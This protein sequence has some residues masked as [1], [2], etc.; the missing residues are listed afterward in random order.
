MARKPSL[1]GAR[2]R[3]AD[4]TLLDPFKGTKDRPALKSD[5]IRQQQKP[6]QN[7]SAQAT[8]GFAAGVSRIGGPFGTFRPPAHRI[9]RSRTFLCPERVFD[10]PHSNR[11]QVSIRPDSHGAQTPSASPILCAKISSHLPALLRASVLFG[12]N[13]V[14]WV[15]GP[16]LGLHYLVLAK[17]LVPRDLYVELL[18]R[19]HWTMGSVDNVAFLEFGHRGTVLPLLALDYPQRF[20]QK[21]LDSSHAPKRVGSAFQRRHAD[22]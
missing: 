10:Y 13:N 15:Q 8:A 9:P 7:V 5:P 17:P 22:L 2:R 12:F 14:A 21:P 20:K 16:T 18:V 6:L 3:P 11:R 1:L 19:F 4:L